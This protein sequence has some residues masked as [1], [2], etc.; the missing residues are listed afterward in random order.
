MTAMEEKRYCIFC[1][2]EN[3]ADADTCAICGKTM[4][5]EENLLKEYLYRTTKARLRGKAEDSFL[6]ILK[7]WILSHMYGL[8]LTISLVT[9]AAVRISGSFTSQPSYVRTVSAGARPDVLA[10]S[11]GENGTMSTESGSQETPGPPE[12]EENIELTVTQEDLFETSHLMYEY[13]FRFIEAAARARGAYMETDD[14]DS[15]L[16]RSSME[17]CLVPADYGYSGA[18]EYYELD[19]DTFMYDEVS[20]TEEDPLINEPTTDLGKRI[21][22]DGHPV[23]E[24]VA[25]T[26]YSGEGTSRSLSF[27]YVTTRLDGRWYIA[28]ILGQ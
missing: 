8:V 26:N 22:A 3:T 2:A 4:H 17:D 10:E 5:P 28:E 25:T 7:N 21:L 6:S 9:L 16:E 13:E 11:A 18:L 24:Y 1:G 23:V 12:P 14:H 15:D 27:K 20:S 19:P